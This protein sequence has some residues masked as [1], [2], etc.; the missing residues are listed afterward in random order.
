MVGNHFTDLAETLPDVQLSD[1]NNND[2]VLS[3]T[4]T[5]DAPRLAHPELQQPCS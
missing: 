3:R 5:V 1:R 4:G 2:Q